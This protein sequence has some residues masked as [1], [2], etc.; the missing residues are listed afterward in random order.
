MRPNIEYFC[1]CQNTPAGMVVLGTVGVGADQTLWLDAEQHGVTTE[2][3]KLVEGLYS[4]P[5]A[6]VS[7]DDGRVYVNA[8]VIADQ[9]DPRLGAMMHASIDQV[10]DELHPT[11]FKP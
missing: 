2:M 6:I 9:C 8:R 1:R 3:L 10:L 5:V 7:N 4:T 11:N